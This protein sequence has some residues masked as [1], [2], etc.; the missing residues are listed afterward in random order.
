MWQEGKGRAVAYYSR[1]TIGAKNVYAATEL[2]VLW[3]V[4]M[5]EHFFYYLY[6]K[7]FVVYT[8]HRALCS[9]LSSDRLSSRLKTDGNEIATLYGDDRL[10]A[11]GG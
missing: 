2:E 8:N 9:L 7:E 11:G 10:Q 1:Q 5:L 4:E 6:G 3:V